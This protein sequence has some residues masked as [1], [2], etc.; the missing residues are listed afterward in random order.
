MMDAETTRAY[1]AGFKLKHT[2]LREEVIYARLEKQGFSEALARQVARD[3]IKENEQEQVKASAQYGLVIA[4]IGLI[5]T[6]A[7]YFIFEDGIYVFPGLLIAG[8]GGAFWLFRQQ[9]KA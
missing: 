1:L 4:A 7:S 2:G 9:D 8:I 3:V 5:G 6:I